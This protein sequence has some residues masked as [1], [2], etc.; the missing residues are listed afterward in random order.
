MTQDGKLANG[1]LTVTCADCGGLWSRSCS[2]TA[3]AIVWGSFHTIAC[4]VYA[5]CWTLQQQQKQHWLW[6]A[7][8]LVSQQKPSRYSCIIYGRVCHCI[9]L[10]CLA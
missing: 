5:N 10:A 3:R 9:D 6:Y 1:E 8:V 4:P 7:L 2:S